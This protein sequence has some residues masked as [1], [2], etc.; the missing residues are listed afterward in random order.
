VR[1]VDDIVVGFEK[2]HEAKQFQEALRQRF[3]Q[4][5]LELHVEKTR[6]MEFGRFARE[7]RHEHGRA[8]PETFTF[9]G[10]THVCGRSRNGRFQVVRRTMAPRLRAKLVEIKAEL[11]W[12]RHQP[13][14]TQGVWLRSVL[15]GHYQYYGVP[16]NAKALQQFRKEVSHLWHRSLSRRSQ[17]GNVNWTRMSR[18][19]DKWLPGGRI[20]HPYPNER[21]GVRT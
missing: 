4:F 18:Y 20:Y 6:L 10:F 2:Y 19:V 8:K 14:P 3:A 7:R 12:R 5:G 21:F 15:L 11:R 16:L 1:Y 13:I 9:L 17:K